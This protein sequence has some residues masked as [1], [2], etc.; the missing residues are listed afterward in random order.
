MSEKI[1]YNR[2]YAR[3]VMENPNNSVINYLKYLIDCSALFRT[4]YLKELD[5]ARIRLHCNILE[6]FGFNPNDDNEYTRSKHI[7]G[8]INKIFKY[9][10]PPELTLRLSSKF[11]TMLNEGIVDDEKVFDEIQRFICMF[12]VEENTRK[13]IKGTLEPVNDISIYEYVFIEP[14]IGLHNY[15]AQKARENHIRE[16]ILAQRRN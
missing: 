8:N 6:E 15:Y 10:L 16:E 12:L 1:E 4:S 7:L 2:E 14:T 5:K 13:F 9:Y 11:I 3:Q